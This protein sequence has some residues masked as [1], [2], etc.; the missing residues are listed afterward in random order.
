M[1]E[2]DREFMQQALQL[3]RRGRG[4][5]S[6][7]PM[8]GAVVVANGEVVG[9]GYHRGPGT[10]HAEALALERAG[11]SSRGATL[12]LSLEPCNHFGRTP[13]CTSAILDAGV[14]RVVGAMPDPDAGVNG[15]GFAAL[16]GHGVDV[17]VGV[18]QEEALRLNEAYV[19]HRRFGRPFVTYK[20]AISLDGRIAAA[21]GSSKWI[22]SDKARAEV[23]RMRANCDAICVGIGTVLTDDPSLTVRW[24]RAAKQPLR[25]VIDTE[26][27]TPPN[28]KVVSKE[29]PTVIV[30]SADR[31][32][33]VPCEVMRVERE[34]DLVSLKAM[35][36]SLAGR[37]V[38][39]LLLE[40]GGI[41]AGNFEAHG[42]IDK[43][44]F[45]VAPKL[46][47]SA[48]TRGVLESWGATSIRNAH[49]L[50]IDSIKRFGEDVR[51]VAYPVKEGGR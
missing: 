30:T 20:A 9:T 11:D 28:A 45:F 25:V 32:T 16:R 22:T 10:K 15:A 49:A 44:V 21:D 18:M 35:L 23:Q 27:R 19:V 13:P 47:G 42:L 6:P 26:L 3:A 12:Y 29:A 40:G 1:A 37:G 50:E 2:R 14:K 36:E 8:V 24:G 38:T 46:L 48:G 39:S 7:N 5:T 31:D 41:L 34:G 4:R 43:Y 33:D 17:E 51:I